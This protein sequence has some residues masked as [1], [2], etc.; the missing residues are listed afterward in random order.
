ME[1]SEDSEEVN[2][3]GRDVRGWKYYLLAGVNQ[4]CKYYF[5]S[6]VPLSLGQICLLKYTRENSKKPTK[7]SSME[8][9]TYQ[10][11]LYH[12]FGILREYLDA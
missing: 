11:I 7:Y 3:T 5:V 2:E 1:G 4:E 12:C 6:K 10:T 9:K 8:L